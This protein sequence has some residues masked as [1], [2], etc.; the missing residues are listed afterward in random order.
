MNPA[1]RL[2]EN[3]G[4]AY[5]GEAAWPPS[6]LTEREA[7]KLLAAPNTCGRPNSDVLRRRLAVVDDAPAESWQIDFPAHFTAQEAAL[8]EQPFASLQKR[9][10]G[11]WLNPHAHP[12]LHRALARVSRYLALPVTATTIDWRW[13][14]EDLLPDATLLVVARDD[15][16]THGILQSP[17]FAAW[18]HAHRTRRLDPVQI[19]E[20][21]P[22][23]WAPATAL[24]A[25]TA[26]QEELR[27]SIARAVRRGNPDQL[28]TVVLAAYG[29][30][31]DRADHEMS[32]RLIA[33]N[34]QRVG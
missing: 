15:D 25:L 7:N 22:F 5:L 19:V 33:L 30:S 6:L 21:F 11:A 4:L 26:E 28:N 1:E 29:W 32:D 14:E 27:H 24:S 23:P 18:H 9:S 31:T 16:F 8:Y 12:D 34:R 2:Q 17:L 20:S 3:T 10:G 13:I